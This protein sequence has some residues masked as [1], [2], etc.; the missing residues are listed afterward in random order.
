MSELLLRGWNV[1]VPVVDVG[2]DAFIIDDRD[3]ATRRIQVKT[4]TAKASGGGF[5]A[6]FGLS[7]NQLK[8]TQPIELFYILLMRVE[9]RWRFLIIPR[10]ELLKIRT[11]E[12]S[13]GAQG[14]QLKSDEDAKA[15]Q[16]TLAIHLEGTGARGW[17]ETLDRFLDC[18]PDDIGI[19]TG[20]PGS[21]G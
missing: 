5:R 3:K 15:D 21:V 8:L 17:G 6:V 9:S 11:T 4:S 7:R 13:K 14:A 12:R 2:D 10:A 20:G 18:W 19:V 16:L 1:A